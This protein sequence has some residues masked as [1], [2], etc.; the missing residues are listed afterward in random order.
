MSYANTIIRNCHIGEIA[1]G[2][3]LYHGARREPFQP[4]IPETLFLTRD[5]KV[6]ANYA[7]D[8]IFPEEAEIVTPASVRMSL[9]FEVTKSL[10]LVELPMDNVTDI[11]QQIFRKKGIYENEVFNS[12]LRIS[13]A[14]EVIDGYVN[15]HEVYLFDP[16][17][18]LKLLEVKSRFEMPSEITWLH[19]HMDGCKCPWPEL[20]DPIVRTVSLYARGVISNCNWCV[21]GARAEAFVLGFGA[22]TES[23]VF[24]NKD[25]A[26]MYELGQSY[27]FSE[28]YNS[29]LPL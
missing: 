23:Q 17:N 16:L 3:I 9:K 2:D 28:K 18:K 8:R 14:P 11:T 25:L 22:T 29:D 21:K 24:I 26:E 10:S 19:E 13:K 15:D 5:F 27:R 7:L 6:H 4:L 1:K 20:D 12:L